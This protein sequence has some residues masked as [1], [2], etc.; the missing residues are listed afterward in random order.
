MMSMFDARY[1]PHL[2]ESLVCDINDGILKHAYS[3]WKHKD[4][5]STL[6]MQKKKS[7]WCVDGRQCVLGWIQKHS[8]CMVS[9]YATQL[10]RLSLGNIMRNK[11]KWHT[12]GV[13]SQHTGFSYI[14][15]SYRSRV[16]LPVALPGVPFTNM[17]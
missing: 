17:D 7:V 14:K 12:V 1:Q 16:L 5:K 10:A 4:S 13:W 15:L 9:E 8:Y 11:K 2:I 6:D 3:N